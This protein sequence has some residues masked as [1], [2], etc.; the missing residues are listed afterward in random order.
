L[1]EYKQIRVIGK[2]GCDCAYWPEEHANARNHA[3][4]N[5]L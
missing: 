3:Q 4:E 5:Q 1:P 2:R